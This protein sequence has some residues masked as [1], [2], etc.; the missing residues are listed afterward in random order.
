MN[1]HA[2]L[3]ASDSEDGSDSKSDDQGKKRRRRAKSK[4]AKASGADA[5]DLWAW[6]WSAGA[7]SNESPPVTPAGKRRHVVKAT[8]AQSRRPVASESKIEW[9]AVIGASGVTRGGQQTTEF[10]VRY[11]TGEVFLVKEE[12]FD[13][14]LATP[15]PKCDRENLGWDAAIVGREVAVFWGAVGYR[16]WVKGTVTGYNGD[17]GHHTICWAEECDKDWVVD[18]MAIAK[19]KCREWR[20]V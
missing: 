12:D 11:K 4:Q 9:E 1:N 10:A 14:H 19:S 3:D 2:K 18:L 15:H 7:N 16:D 13:L 6:V 20:L 5:D 17:D 8:D